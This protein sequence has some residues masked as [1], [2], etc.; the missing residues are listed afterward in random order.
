MDPSITRLLAAGVAALNDENSAA[1]VP[2]FKAA[3]A[4][5]DAAARPHD[6]DYAKALVNLGRCYMR[7]YEP[8]C[9]T[10]LSCYDRALAIIAPLDHASKVVVLYHAECEDDRGEVFAE[11]GHTTEATAAYETSLALFRRVNHREREVRVLTSLALQCGLTGQLEK[12]LRFLDLAE[13]LTKEGAPGF[14][15]KK[16]VDARPLCS[17]FCPRWPFI[18]HRTLFRMP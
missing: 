15:D 17:R 6:L 4:K 5:W 16:K 18:L 9:I 14:A 13:T 8:E 2:L 1:A 7:G 11:M 3:I 10:A 12:G